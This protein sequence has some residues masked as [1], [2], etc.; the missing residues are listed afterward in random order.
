M[1]S[2]SWAKLESK[3]RYLVI[4][5]AVFVVLALL[6]DF[7]VFPFFQAKAKLKKNIASNE[8]KLEEMVKM[9]AEFAVQDAKISRI[10]NAIASRRPD[11]TLFSYLE[12]KA[13][14]AHVK[15]A[16]KQMNSLQGGKTAFFDETLIDLKLE[17]ITVKQLED[18]L[19]QVES[20]TELIRIKRLTITKMKE[21]P[22]YISVQILVASYTPAVLGAVVP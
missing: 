18:F 2:D 8:K 12:K 4:G 3:Q 16:I 1:M 22:E 5:C 6:L 17:K 21:S 11:F 20:P 10:R 15:G 7:V 19:Y 13:Y 14:S 9:D